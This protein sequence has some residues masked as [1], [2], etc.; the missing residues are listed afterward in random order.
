[1]GAQRIRNLNERILAHRDDRYFTA[2]IFAL[3]PWPSEEGEQ[4]R[5][6]DDGLHFTAVGY[7][8]VGD[9]VAE[10]IMDLLGQE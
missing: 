10:K 7:G 4:D 2:D 9:V 3:I 1:M 6:W 5:I 8:M